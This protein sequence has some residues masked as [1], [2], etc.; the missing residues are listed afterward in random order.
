MKKTL[1]FL[2]AAIAALACVSCPLPL[3]LLPG[4][5]GVAPALPVDI[6]RDVPRS[7]AGP[8]TYQTLLP[9][10][11]SLDVTLYDAAGTAVPSAGVG[12][13]AT[14]LNQK[15]NVVYAGRISDGHLGA[16]IM[17]PAAPEN[18]TLSLRAE[19]CVGRSVVI[20]DAVAFAEVNRTMGMLLQPQRAKSPDSLT[21][22]RDGD[23][24]PDVYDAFP[25]DP[26]SAFAYRVPADGNLTVAYE[27]LYGL[28]QAG[29]ADYND[30]IAEYSITEVTNGT[31][32]LHRI[33]VDAQEVVKLAAYD[34]RFGI[35]VDTFKGSAH[36]TGASIDR[37][38]NSVS[39]DRIET[40]HA[41]IDLFAKSDTALL[42]EA[43]FTLEFDEPQV[44]DPAS[45]TV[46]RPPY[47]PYLCVLDTGQEIHLMG[48]QDRVGTAHSYQ[49]SEGFPWGLLVPMDWVNPAEAERIEVHYPRFTNWRQNFGAEFTDWYLHYD[50]PWVPPPPDIV[51]EESRVTS[52][53]DQE[54][55]PR[56]GRD[57]TGDIV[58]YTSQSL[59]PDGNYIGDIRYQ[60]YDGVT[61]TWGPAVTISDSATDDKF[62]DISGNL[63]VYTAFAGPVS[64]V[65]ALKVYDIVEGT[66]VDLLPEA[67]S[68]R[69]GRID[70]SVVVWTQ[71]ENGTTRIVYRDLA[72]DAG[73][74]V[75]LAGPSPAASNVEIGSRYVVWEKVA[76]TQKDI[77]AYD[78]LTGAGITVS[79]D[80]TLDE[81]LPSTS[82]KW[83]VWQAED[84]S[85]VYTLRAANLSIKPVTASAIVD[86]GS[87]VGRPSIDG[88]LVAYESDVAGSLD[89]Y[90]YR[91]S[92][93]RIFRV[94]DD[95]S[96]QFLVNL[97]G[98]KVAYI[99]NRSGSYDV[100]VATFSLPPVE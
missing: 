22:D 62:N 10:K 50:D 67:G 5:S 85:G 73:V 35:R 37:H 99:D 84:A 98:D 20:G 25:D 83:V 11:L 15:G 41:N 28:A 31:N 71:G 21:D 26:D 18:L 3:P 2:A 96:D 76:G 46:D 47:N 36:L 40:G 48:E 66:T 90:I 27:D 29:D 100:Y 32:Q 38:G 30:F 77:A 59:L 56:L 79:A 7:T 80:A 57:D 61:K 34:H 16:L 64:T 81:R 53:V 23:L 91:I 6:V 54:S 4:V 24:V 1:V 39:I 33:E 68:V 93:A 89:I 52:S 65:G 74:T 13:I 42:K 88:D 19:G 78:R 49:D 43:S 58:V 14:L 69:E 87:Y 75:T 97:F 55:L 86:N 12:V 9:V 51:V 63:I 70:G 60:R 8:F 45:A 94:T 95:A 92:D 44:I 17:L 72:W 82:G